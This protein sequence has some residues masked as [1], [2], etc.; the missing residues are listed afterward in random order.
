MPVSIGR[1]EWIA[2]AVLT[3]LIAWFST[4]HALDFH[5]DLRL[6]Y[7][8]D[9]AYFLQRVWQAAFLEEPH[10]TVLSTEVGEGLVV[11]RHVEPILLLAVPVVRALPRMEALLVFQALAL[12]LVFPTTWRLSR[13]E[14]AGPVAALVGALSVQLVPGIWTLSV[15]DFRT[16]SLALPCLL[17]ALLLLRD[18]RVLGGCL[19]T[20]AALACREEV[21]LLLLAC[22][23]WLGWRTRSWRVVAPPALLAASYGLALVLLRGRTSDFLVSGDLPWLLRNFDPDRLGFAL[24]RMAEQLGPLGVFLLASPLC[25]VIA[26]PTVA[27]AVLLEG[28]WWPGEVH[29]SLGLFVAVTLAAVSALGAASRRGKRIGIAV[30]GL[31]LCGSLVAWLHAF[32]PK[33]LGSALRVAVGLDTPSTRLNT[34]WTVFAQVPE[35]A[36]LVTQDRFIAQLA[37]R[38]V[39]YVAEDWRDPLAQQQVVGAVRYAVFDKDHPWD[40]LLRE[41]GFKP[42]RAGGSALLYIREG[43]A[44][45]AHL[46]PMD[47]GLVSQTD[48][49]SPCPI[50]MVHLTNARRTLGETDPELLDRYGGGVLASATVEVEAF[51]VDRL[52]FP[53][54]QGAAWPADGLVEADLEELERRLAEH[55]RRLC[56]VAELMRAASG[57]EGP[58]H[59]AAR[60]SCATDDNAPGPLGSH[61]DCVSAAGAADFG[62]RSTWAQLVA[63]WGEGPVVWGGS[64]RTDTYYAPNNYGVHEHGEDPHRYIDDGLR[65]CSDPGGVTLA[66]ERGW[67]D[68]VTRFITTGSFERWLAQSG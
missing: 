7:G 23:P 61:P 58:A 59:P 39:V 62:V 22:L 43:E 38:S 67:S 13:V 25:W 56:T 19:A 50:G 46:N 9:N 17:L 49:D 5:W 14:G 11:G 10:R 6:V 37:D 24:P 57:F 12:C 33:E 66:Q 32:P 21:Y 35:G 65:V 60:R 26:L 48:P 45:L 3:L 2:V 27:A 63:P 42:R 29:L 16:L 41:Q 68:L 36:P 40:A 47:V 55:G 31:A 54:R 44:P 53:G 20:L 15:H 30:A 52:P 4:A 8:R 51:C 34:P 64:A 18:G 1:A 28:V